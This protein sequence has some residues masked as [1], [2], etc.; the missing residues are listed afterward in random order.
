M[1][2][3]YLIGVIVIVS[4][5][6]IITTFVSHRAIDRQLVCDANGR[7]VYE[8]RDGFFCVDPDD[9]RVFRPVPTSS[10]LPAWG[11]VRPLVIAPGVFP[12]VGGVC[13]T[14]GTCWT[15]RTFSQLCYMS[16]I[17]K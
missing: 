6:T 17:G 14:D 10:P 5:A 8:V 16:D 2:R 15:A 7:V 1:I 4:F 9:G 12:A 3:L 11:N 13:C